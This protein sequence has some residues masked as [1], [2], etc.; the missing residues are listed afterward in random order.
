MPTLKS[1]HLMPLERLAYDP[2]SAAAALGIGREL[3]EAAMRTSD[4]K[5]R[6][7]YF[8]LGRR[9]VIPKGSLE[10]WLNMQVMRQVDAWDS[11]IVTDSDD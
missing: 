11:E 9:V 8:R 10:N 7:G 6:L 3:L 1:K 2:D 5:Y 4:I